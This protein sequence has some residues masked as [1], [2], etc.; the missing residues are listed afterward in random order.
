MRDG[1]VLVVGSCIGNGV[2]T[3]YADIFDPQ[4][5]SWTEAMPA[6]VAA[7]MARFCWRMAVY[8]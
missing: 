3:G 8:W 1:R 6:G 2:C 7:S 4:T 5:N